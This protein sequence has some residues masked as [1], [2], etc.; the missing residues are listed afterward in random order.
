MRIVLDTNIILKALIKNSRVRGILLNPRHQFYVP[1]YAVEET[2]KHI[3]V[4]KEKTG[5]SESEIE[6]VFDVLLSN[7]RVIPPKRVMR[8]FEEAQSIMR[9]IDTKD[10]PFV[11]A[12]LSIA[13]DGIWSDDVHLKRQSRVRV[14]NTR[15]MVQL[16]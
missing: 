8:R 12:A 10:A 7:L 2:R 11:A 14:W 1:E 5:L 16:L 3:L 15:E 6:R 9:S 13:S 4:V